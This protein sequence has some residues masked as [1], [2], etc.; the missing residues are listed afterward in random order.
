MWY[1]GR[2]EPDNLIASALAVL[3][4]QGVVSDRRI[5]GVWVFGSHAR[6]TAHSGS[7]L[8]LAVLCEPALEL[9]RFRLMDTL[10]RRLERDVDVIDLGTAP[11]TLVW[12][13]LTTGRLVLESDA[14]GVEAFVRHARFAAEDAEQR[15][16]MILLAQIAPEGRA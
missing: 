8:D 13:V 11:P 10:A 16:R 7:D 4:E 3:L 2:V 5:I 12:E 1:S 14:L 15:D 9:D 6:G